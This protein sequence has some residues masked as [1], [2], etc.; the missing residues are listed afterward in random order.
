MNPSIDLDL[1]Q[2]AGFN[3]TGRPFPDTVTLMELFEAQVARTPRQPA[4]FC[5]H[6]KFWGRSMLTFA[7]FNERANQVGHY[8]RRQ[9]VRPGHIVGII[10]ERSFAMLIGIFGILK[11]GGAY[12]PL[13]PDDPPERRQ[14]V[15]ADAGVTL[16]LVH[17]ATDKWPRRPSRPSMWSTASSMP[18]PGKIRPASTCPRTS[19]T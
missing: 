1:E 9:G 2:I 3:R 11:A 13:S 10:V 8:L 19:P 16:L 18:A 14:F 4:L 15:L 17:A 6:D 12:L 7:E 5:D